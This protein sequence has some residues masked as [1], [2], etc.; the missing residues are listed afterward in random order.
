MAQKQLGFLVDS[1]KCVGCRGCEMACKNEYQINDKLRWRK[2]YTLAEEEYSAPERNHMSLA[3]NH[4]VEPECGRVC[5]VDAYSKRE[6][7]IVLH[8]QSKCI[9][10]RFCMMACPYEVPQFNEEIK[11]VE[12]CELC[13]KRLDAGEEPACIAGCIPGAL[14][15]IDLNQFNETEAK[16]I[17]PGFPDPSITDPSVRFIPPHIGVQIRSDEK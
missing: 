17:L 11:K 6:D 10:C 4:C 15:L 8:D 2:V 7:G 16:R 12:K 3:C 9:G 5:P 13:Y 1:E 14:K